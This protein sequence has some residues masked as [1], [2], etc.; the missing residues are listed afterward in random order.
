MKKNLVVFV[1]ILFIINSVAYS[2]NNLNE[3]K[4]SKDIDSENEIEY[5]SIF[6][7]EEVYKYSKD[8]LSDIRIINDNNEFVPYYIYNEYLGNKIEK[9]K[10]YSSKKVLTFTDKNKDKYMDFEILSEEENVDIIGNQ[11]R[12]FVNNESFLENI[13]IYASYDNENWNY[14]KSDIIYKTKDTEHQTVNLDNTYKYSFY[15]VVFLKNIDNTQIEDIELVYNYKDAKYE[16][17]KKTTMVDYNIELDDLRNTVITIDNKNNLKINSIDIITNDDFK[18]KY[19]LLYKNEKS[20]DFIRAKE[21]EIYNIQLK[22]FNAQNTSIAPNEKY[23]KED[24][25]RILIINKDNQPININDIKIDYY[26]NK[27][28]FKKDESKK[29]KILFGNDDANI[30]NYDIESYIQHIEKEKQEVCSLSNIEKIN[31]NEKDVEKRK[32]N[33]KIILNILVVIIAIFLVG[34]ILKK[35]NFKDM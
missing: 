27:I 7:D 17:Y 32:I 6:L 13:K 20:E 2:E 22:N 4:Y 29:Y 5:K 30:P 23:Y 10:I 11:I 34:I 12:L 9:E 28:V 15:R 18:R 3:W 14:I 35:A 21:G 33:Y 8:N 16:N 25:Y 1:F 19:Y 26:I 24:K 31:T